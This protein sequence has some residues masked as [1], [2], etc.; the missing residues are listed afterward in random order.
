MGNLLY[1]GMFSHLPRLFVLLVLY[2]P[3]HGKNCGD[4]TTSDQEGP[5]YEAGA[6]LDWDLAP[7]SELVDSSLGVVLSG[8]IF[9][10]NCKGIPGATVEVWYAGKTGMNY[11]FPPDKL[12]YRGKQQTGQ[13]GDYVFFATI[14]EIYKDRPIL[15]YHYMVTTPGSSGKT[16]ITQAYFKDKIPANFVSYMRGR[17]TQM[18]SLWK[19]PPGELKN[20]GRAMTFNIKMNVN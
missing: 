10:K 14:P 15:H 7:A 4:I 2:Y 9:N 1:K 6:D 17:D 18:T 20:G 8:R 3:V 16:K 11:T 12:W 19:L 5:F 13:N